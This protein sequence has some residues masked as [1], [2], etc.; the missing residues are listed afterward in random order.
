MRNIC[1]G[2]T[3]SAEEHLPRFDGAKLDQQGVMKDSN[4]SQ[5]ADYHEKG[6]P[7]CMERYGPLL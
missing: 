5:A 3:S 6:I 7:Y 2:G 1:R 4:W